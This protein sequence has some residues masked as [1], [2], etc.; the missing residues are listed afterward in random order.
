MSECNEGLDQ[1]KY[2]I[3]T[4]IQVIDSTNDEVVD[5]NRHCMCVGVTYDQA[6]A[7]KYL[8]LG[9]M[10]E[11]GAK[12]FLDVIQAGNLDAVKALRDQN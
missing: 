9:K 5:D 10:V 1:C 3:V 12:S 4:T 7:I 11:A 6:M 8:Q 2:K